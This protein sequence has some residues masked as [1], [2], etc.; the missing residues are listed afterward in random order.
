MKIFSKQ[1]VGISTAATFLVGLFALPLFTQAN[2]SIPHK[3]SEHDFPRV[4]ALQL[5]TGKSSAMELSKFDTVILQTNAQNSHPQLI[6]DLRRLNP[7]IVILAY[8]SAVED[9]SGRLWQVEPEGYGVWHDLSA[10][11]QDPWRLKT[12]T[13]QQVSFWP[14]HTGMNLTTKDSRGISYADYLSEFLAN[15][16]LA[17]GY[18]DGLLFDTTWETI[19]WF[20]D[21][22]DMNGDGRKD[23]VSFIDQQWHAGQ[24]D[25]LTKLRTRTGNKYLLITNGDGQFSGVNNGRMFEGFPEFWEGGWEGSVERYFAT[26]ASGYTPRFNI[27]NSDTD[28]TGNFGNY[29]FVRFGLTSA[30]LGNGYFNFDYGTTDRSHVPYYD[31]YSVSLGRPTTGAFDILSSASA[32]TLQVQPGVWRR[33]FENGISLVNSSNVARTITLPGEFEKLHGTQDP[34]TNNGR[35]VSKVTIPAQDGLVLLNP[36]KEVIN[37]VYQNGNYARIF[38]ANSKVSRSSFFSF[39]ERFSGGTR[40]LKVDLEEDNRL[41]TIVAGKSAITI[42]ADNGSVRS[43]FYPYTRAYQSG[44]NL[45]VGD[46]NG[47]GTKEIITGTEVGGGPQIRIFNKNGKLI[48]PGFFAYAEAFRGGVHVAVGDLNGDG[49]NEIIAGAGYGG[50][51]HIR[52]FNKDGKL[53]NP[54]FFAYDPAFRGGVH[55]ATGDIDGNGIDEVI[56][57]PGPGGGPHVR[58]WNNDGRMLTEFFG[59]TAQ[60]TAGVEVGAFDYDGDRR[61]EIVTMTSD[62]FSFN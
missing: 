49:I 29:A 5:N 62:F 7:D 55:V 33:D 46:L 11:I 9:F 8:A 25:F 22:I 26:D 52:I 34:F 56:S 59:F 43:V 60:S 4:A 44:I 18:W 16:V 2:H 23:T 39:D 27:I 15:Q 50:G 48:N 51:P 45:G 54:G 47:D 40:I 32:T 17:T 3:T 28:N 21:D 31:E 24:E 38:S 10:G 35:V 61:D 36:L 41:E 12:W 19:S 53:I 30:M 57:G 1:F 13:G 6:R 14:G 37:G 20:S 58:V 42:Y